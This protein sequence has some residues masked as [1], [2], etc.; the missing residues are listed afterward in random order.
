MSADYQIRVDLSEMLAGLGGV[1]NAYV[2]PTVHQAVKAVASEAAYRWKDGVAK[3]K[4]WNGEKQAYIES[5]N[6]LMLSDF[7]AIVSTTYDQAG[8]IE[9]GR[10][11]YDMKKRLNTSMK[12]RVAKHGKH[13]GM[14]YLIIPMRH[15]TPGNVALAQAMP[16]DIYKKAKRLDP[17][18]ITGTASR[19]SGTGAIS[20]CRSSSTPGAGSCPPGWRQSS[21]RTIRPTFMPACT[22]S[23]PA[24]A[25][26]NLRA[27]TRSASWASGSPTSGS[28]RPSRACTLPSRCRIR[29]RSMRPKYSNRRSLT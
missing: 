14:R 2:L 18:I 9:T 21:S 5:I 3:A 22:D 17:S 27:T 23:T 15:N 24:P 28:F 1:I 8:A 25:R 11:A 19:P 29:S 13:A 4:L 7:E 12:V 26:A 16:E 20:W 6:W 10:P